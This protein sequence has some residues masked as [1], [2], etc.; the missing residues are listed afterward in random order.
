MKKEPEDRLDSMFREGLGKPGQRAEF[1]EADW[2]ALENTLD[3]QQ[4]KNTIIF[5]LPIISGVAAMLLLVLGWLFIKP[6]YTAHHNQLTK[7]YKAHKGNNGQLKSPI[8]LHKGSIQT[9]ND[10]G[11]VSQ[12]SIQGVKKQK[13]PIETA[14][15][16][17]HLQGT[18][19]NKKGTNITNIEDAYRDALKTNS[20]TDRY[21]GMLAATDL[22]TMLGLNLN[23]EPTNR[24]IDFTPALIQPP[25]NIAAIKPAIKQHTTNR[26]Q[27]ALT[28]L[29]ANDINGVNSF[30]QSKIGADAGLLFSVQVSKKFTLSTG[31]IYAKKPYMANAESYAVAYSSYVK[32]YMRD[33]TADCRVL[34]IP[35]NID[36]QLYNNSKN[37]FSIGTGL[38][39][40]FML[41]ENYH[42]NYA[43]PYTKGPTDYTI[44][45]KNQHFFGVLNLDATYQRK[46]NSKISINLQPYFKI[47]LTNIGYGKVK[48]Q[49]AGVAVG[50]SWNLN[51]LNKN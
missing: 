11:K 40:Y 32:S 30:R 16:Y 42:Y 7:A 1:R 50:I 2:D 33:V 6:N 38:S 41:R 14:S 19:K 21:A 28:V 46:L 44:T 45:N 8:V 9:G 20:H 5:W 10:T 49:T 15:Y 29:A 39:S 26:P 35:I 18:A 51:S 17:A 24:S 48:L 25:S 13:Q 27:F 23:D 43:T 12:N 37:K 4:K 31:A 36:Y 34:D 47:P 22:Q 3:K